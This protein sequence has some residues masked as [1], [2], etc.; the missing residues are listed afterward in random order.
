MSRQSVDANAREALNQMKTEI[1]EELGMN[2]L[3]IPVE[4]GEMTSREYGFY[5]G[6][7]GGEMTRRLVAMGEKE[8]VDK[9]QG[10]GDR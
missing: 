4:K 1:A 7:V 10:E 8:L 2:H 9:Q 3:E 5:G 6:P